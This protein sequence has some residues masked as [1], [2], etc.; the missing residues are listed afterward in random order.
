MFIIYYNVGSIIF[1]AILDKF[2]DVWSMFMWAINSVITGPEIRLGLK[3]GSFL[4]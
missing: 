2:E 3:T 4:K 1:G